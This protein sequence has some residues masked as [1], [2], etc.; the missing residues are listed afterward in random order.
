MYENFQLE[1]NILVVF[2]GIIFNS[3]FQ[4]KKN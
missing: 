3:V 4:V 2:D 1:W